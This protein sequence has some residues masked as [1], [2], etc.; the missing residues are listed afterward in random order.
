LSWEP[1]DLHRASFSGA[2]TQV[3]AKMVVRLLG[4]AA[5]NVAA[6][7]QAD[8]PSLSAFVPGVSQTQPGG[9]T[10]ESEGIH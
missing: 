4:D 5:E 10:G 9:G 7:R 8:T 1:S 6:G 3:S 2:E